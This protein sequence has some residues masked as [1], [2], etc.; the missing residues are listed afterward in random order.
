MATNGEQSPLLG[1]NGTS[2]QRIDEQ[3][4]AR[5]TRERNRALAAT[6]GVLVFILAVVLVA[7]FYG[8]SLSSDPL[9]AAYDVLKRSPVIVRP[10]YISIQNC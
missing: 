1:A 9:L 10:T 2:E 4:A 6:G 8:D 7:V 5:A 3:L